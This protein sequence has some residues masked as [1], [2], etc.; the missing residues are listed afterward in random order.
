LTRAKPVEFRCP[1]QCRDKCPDAQEWNGRK[2]DDY[3]VWLQQTHIKQG[4]ACDAR[5][6]LCARCLDAL[7]RAGVIKQ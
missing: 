4:E 3:L 1:Q 7:E 5:R 2:D 6:Q